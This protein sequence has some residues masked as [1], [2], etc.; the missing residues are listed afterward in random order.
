[1]S[2]GFTFDGTHSSAKDLKVLRIHRSVL[3]GSRHR[4]QEV[5]G[6][7]GAYLFPEEPGDR[8]VVALC[9]L[10]GASQGDLIS[11][12]RNV[13]EWLLTRSRERLVLDDD[14]SW[15]LNAIVVNPAEVTDALDLG[16]FE[17]EF[18]CDPYVYALNESSASASLGASV[19]FASAEVPD[20]PVRIVV[21][22]TGTVVGPSVTVGGTTI[23]YAGTIVAGEA[24]IWDSVDLLSL[25]VDGATA[26]AARD[27]TWDSSLGTPILPQGTFPVASQGTVAVLTAGSGTATVVVFW[28][29]RRL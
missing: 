6:R 24:I 15:W 2:A 5:P 14:P 3:P 10:V 11:Q 17:V 25:L 12:E 18:R 21:Y 27:G 22:A 1:M 7:A 8:A 4:F 29:P 23:G 9:G 28:R 20:V 16:Q 13:A 26:T 19:T